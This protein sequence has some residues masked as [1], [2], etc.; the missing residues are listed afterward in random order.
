MW[1]G[2]ARRWLEQAI[3]QFTQGRVPE[4]PENLAAEARVLGALTGALIGQGEN[5]AALAAATEGIALARRS[6][7][8][9]ALAYTLGMAALAN[10][11]LGRPEAVMEVAEESIAIARRLDLK[12]ELSLIFSALA[13]L[14]LY[15]R[16]DPAQ[17]RVYVDEVSRIALTLQNPWFKA[18]E[19]MTRARL[20][21]LEHDPATAEA[22]LATA[23]A[24]FD[25]VGDSH[26]SAVATSDRAHVL[27]HQGRLD[28]SRAIYRHMIVFWQ[29]LGHRAAVAHQLECL[30]F[31]AADAQSRPERAARLLAAADAI[32]HTA[33][34]TRMPDEQL[35]YDAAVAALRA[36]LGES[37][38]AAAWAEGQAMTID[39]AVAYALD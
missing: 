38:W 37:A 31:I 20:A 11:Y 25:Q 30:A 5:T 26:F 7:D 14:S 16:A 2:E 1:G 34:S 39:Q 13:G 23:A 21:L 18:M 12:W 9:H 6:G 22:C 32:R 10:G 15:S 3:G 36:R 35:E 8:P 28:E 27:R 24:L 33:D 29:Q 19:T 17:A 4:T